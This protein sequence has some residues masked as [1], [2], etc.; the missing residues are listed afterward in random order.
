MDN[1]DRAIHV[2]PAK[3][4]ADSGLTKREHF[5]ALA[6][7]GLL[8]GITCDTEWNEREV[9]SIAVTCA[10]ALLEELEGEG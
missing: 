6:M 3:G 5:A 9:S 1:K 10:D 4:C 7:Q 2:I 8:S